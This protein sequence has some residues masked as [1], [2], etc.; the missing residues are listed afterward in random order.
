MLFASVLAAS[1]AI[2][3]AAAAPDDALELAREALQATEAGSIEGWAFTETS[4]ENG[5][6]TVSRFDPRR[7]EGGQWSLVSVNDRPPTDEERQASAE[8]RATE[9]QA[10][11][12]GGNGDG[13]SVEIGVMIE[14]DSLR[15]IEETEEFA[16]YR[17][18]PAKD[19][20]D[21]SGFHQHVD[22][23]L[24]VVKAGPYVATIDMR[25]RAPFK[26]QFGVKIDEFATMLTFEPQDS[27]GPVLPRTVSVRVAGRA[28][29]VKKIDEAVEVAYSDYELV[30]P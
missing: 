18:D 21:D 16:L 23:T 11:E 9:R 28:F 14:P 20:D 15:L 4:V 10:S 6:K 24:K 5:R 1:A 25:S 26:P 27:G 22:A 29:L 7:P 8:R 2:Q 13:E 30:G 12:S 17:F 3:L 19:D